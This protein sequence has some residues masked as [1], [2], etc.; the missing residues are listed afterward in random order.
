MFKLMLTNLQSKCKFKLF[1]NSLYR[2]RGIYIL[3]TEVLNKHRQRDLK[4]IFDL[5]NINYKKI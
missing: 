4:V 1:D 2:T 3:E 5:R